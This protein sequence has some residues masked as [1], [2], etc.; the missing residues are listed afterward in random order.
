MPFMLASACHNMARI[1]FFVFSICFSF[2][3]IRKRAENKTNYF[4]KNYIFRSI[5]NY[6]LLFFLFFCRVFE[7]QSSCRMK[8]L[9]IIRRLK[10][11]LEPL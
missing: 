8:L 1:L 6:S 2:P 5:F 4:F 10:W 7:L 11:D 3:L 9:L